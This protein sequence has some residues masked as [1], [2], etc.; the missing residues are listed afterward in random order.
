[1]KKILV[2]LACVA[3]A[4]TAVP[5]VASAA[6]AQADLDRVAAEVTAETGAPVGIAL[7]DA[8][9]TR[10]AG[11]I[12]DFPAYSTGKVPL[13]IAALRHNPA[14]TGDATA[15]ITVSD[16]AAADRLW[17]ALGGWQ[18]TAKVN[19]V[20]H[21]GGSTTVNPGW[22]AMPSWTVADQAA[23]FAA[24][25]C[26]DK[27]PEVEAMMGNVVDYQRWAFGGLPGAKIKGGWLP[28]HGYSLRQGAILPVG[29]GWVG[30][31]VAVRTPDNNFPRAS[32]AATRAANKLRPLLDNSEPLTCAG[33][34]QTQSAPGA[35]TAPTAPAVP[36][37]PIGHI[38]I[39]IP[40]AEPLVA[41]ANG[42]ID[43]LNVQLRRF[44]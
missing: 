18:A 13:A 37:G 16:N 23:F 4:A 10:S 7:H 15:A 31:S 39:P 33:P 32:D 8:S 25:P 22:W 28:E 24:I 26:V 12:T 43:Q 41:W 30:A 34:V 21:D 2:A 44:I 3:T 29:G 14:L 38:A 19:A 36:T 35:P 42:L 6:V 17:S 1:M 11:T 27:G 20:L 5:S 9:G 40:G